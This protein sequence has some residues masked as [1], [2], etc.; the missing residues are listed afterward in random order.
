[1]E[2]ESKRDGTDDADGSASSLRAPEPANVPLRLGTRGSA[3]ARWQAEWVADRLRDLGQD[4]QLILIATQGDANLRPLGEIGGQGVFTKEIQRALLD[5]RIDFAVHSLKDLPTEP[6]EGLTLAAI[7]PRESNHDVLVC[8]EAADLDGLPSG[9]RVGTGSTRRRA[10]LLYH[11]PDLTVAD[12]RG[13]VETRLRKLAEGQFDAIVLAE[14]GLRRLG[15][16]RHVTQ[17]LPRSLMLPAV[18]QGALGIESRTDD[19][20]ALEALAALN[21]PETQASVLTERSMLSALRAGCL[22]P[23]GAWARIEDGDLRLD[24]I[25]LSPDGRERLVVSVSGPASEPVETGAEA[26]RRLIADGADRLIGDSR[27]RLLLS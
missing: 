11:R 6:V 19:Q 15:L 21:H 14:A 23:V 2:P 7:P 27:G 25:V 9:S 3:L 4:V 16:E 10:Q 26:A 1:M 5:G 12:I 13:N 24:G 18:G 17:I 20:A 8:R 22:A